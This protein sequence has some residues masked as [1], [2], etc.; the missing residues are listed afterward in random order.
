MAGVANAQSMYVEG[1]YKGYITDRGE[2]YIGSSYKGYCEGVKVS[3]K[4]IGAIYF[5]FFRD[6]LSI[7][8][9]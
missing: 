3:K 2:V 5:F 8:I 1:S 4:V 9:E 6:E 7:K